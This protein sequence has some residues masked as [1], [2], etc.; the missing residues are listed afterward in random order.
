MKVVYERFVVPESS[1]LR[2]PS[3]L[4]SSLHQEPAHSGKTMM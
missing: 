2:E 1:S 4:A 3:M